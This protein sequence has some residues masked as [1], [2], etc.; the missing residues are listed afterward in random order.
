ML[1]TFFCVVQTASALLK[2]DA[3]E[4]TG[5]S[6]MPEGIKAH[7]HTHRLRRTAFALCVP[8]R[9]EKTLRFFKKA[10]SDVIIIPSRTFVFLLTRDCTCSS[11]M[12][13]CHS[14][15][16]PWVD[17]LGTCSC[18]K[19]ISQCQHF[20]EALFRV[21]RVPSHRPDPLEGLFICLNSKYLKTHLNP[22]DYYVVFN[23]LGL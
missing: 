2:S 10:L 3:H 22:R 16:K 21:R 17:F 18:M 8:V 23:S 13:R 9:F 1:T 11:S 4:L 7:L 19:L 14:L 15:W 12:T 20:Y 6:F 5:T